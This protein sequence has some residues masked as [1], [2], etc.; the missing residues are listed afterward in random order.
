MKWFLGAA[1]LTAAAASLAQTDYD[2]VTVKG[3]QV[4]PGVY[5]LAGAGG[6]IGASIGKDGTFLIDDQFA[7]LTEKIVAELINLGGDIPRFLINTH[8][9]FD[10]TGGNENFG[11]ANTVIVAHDNV[12]KRMSVDN[13]IKAFNREVP[14]AGKDALP[15]ITFDQQMTFHLNGQTI[16]VRHLQNAHT[17]GDAA[18]FFQEANVLHTGDLFFNGFYPFIDVEHGGSLDGMA[19]A[20]R[21]LLGDIDENTRVIPG[22]GPLATKQELEAYG[23]MLAAVAE[24]IATLKAEGKSV[25]EIIAAKP[26]AQ[27]DEQW[28]NGMFAP[29]KWVE[30]VSK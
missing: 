12:R 15:V 16:R 27:F 8:W 28:G 4:Q 2:A 3:Q 19:D 9:H 6:N 20:V 7:P 21:E 10:H 1:A 25:A 18:V 5:M 11:R 26:T 22:H 14:A 29:D 24:N 13:V 23:D 30:L 17:D